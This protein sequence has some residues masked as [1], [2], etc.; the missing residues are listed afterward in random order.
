MSNWFP[1]ARC[2]RPPLRGE[3][4]LI[5]WQRLSSM[6]LQRAEVLRRENKLLVCSRFEKDYR[7]LVAAPLDET[8][9]IRPWQGEE[10]MTGQAWAKNRNGK[11]VRKEEAYA[12]LRPKGAAGES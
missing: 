8:I 6:T 5:V 1:I 9:V 11:T 2:T 7:V 10:T 4:S 3:G 12:F